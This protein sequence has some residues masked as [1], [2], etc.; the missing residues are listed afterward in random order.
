MVDSS[1]LITLLIW[2]LIY[3]F[4]TSDVFTFLPLQCQPHQLCSF[5]DLLLNNPPVSSDSQG[6]G[7][8]LF[9]SSLCLYKGSWFKSP[10]VSFCLIYQ[11]WIKMSLNFPTNQKKW[12][13]DIT[14]FRVIYPLVVYLS[15]VKF[16]CVEAC[17]RC[18]IA[19]I[20]NILPIFQDLGI[21][22]VCKG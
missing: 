22:T 7:W 14:H 9:W 11:A 21:G 15:P 10:M 8:Y 2:D 13:S 6:F 3:S 17:L 4:L 12:L 19:L 1:M 18:L 16:R 20:F 5:S